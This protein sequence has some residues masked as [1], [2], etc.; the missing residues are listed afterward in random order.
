MGLAGKKGFLLA[1]ILIFV[2][3]IVVALAYWFV[4]P[5]TKGTSATHA[6][7]PGLFAKS[8]LVL[9]DVSCELEPARNLTSGTVQF[10]KLKYIISNAGQSGVG[11][12]KHIDVV[13]SGPPATDGA[14]DT[15][16]VTTL[17]ERG[18]A[19][20]QSI[21]TEIRS[22][23]FK[24]K[25]WY[26][27][28]DAPIL[29]NYPLA[30][31]E[32]KISVDPKNKYGEES[33]ANNDGKVSCDG[34]VLQ[35]CF[36]ADSFSALKQELSNTEIFCKSGCNLESPVAGVGCGGC[37]NPV[38]IKTLV[39]SGNPDPIC[40][41]DACGCSCPENSVTVNPI[42]D[43]EWVCTE[44]TACNLNKQKRV[45]VEQNGC[46]KTF[47]KPKEEQLCFNTASVEC[48][49]QPPKWSC[50]EGPC[51]SGK[52]TTHCVDVVG[53]RKQNETFAVCNETIPQQVSPGNRCGIK[54][55]D[56]AVAFSTVGENS[57]SV[58]VR[59]WGAGVAGPTNVALYENGAKISIASVGGLDSGNSEVV[60]F[61]S[62][63]DAE[64]FTLKAVVDLDDLVQESNEYN[65]AVSIRPSK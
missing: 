44:W 38:D 20:R 48:V 58:V 41:K 16:S 55:P 50:V 49:G 28:G 7:K 31:G 42:V 4:S 2:I 18:L 13:V 17:K 64:Y 14:I 32:Y 3:L 27:E 8:D 33:E 56:L 24:N 10:S 34:V 36:D 57:V 39:T 30:K 37:K 46:G 61:K 62:V 47:N 43:C 22:F 23:V 59:N 26:A 53:C 35:N 45:C 5:V 51:R 9:K 29:T 65:N 12:N 21:V 60:I 19:S 63:P 25:V 54:L 40:P 11:K 15:Q 1:F 6:A 52:I